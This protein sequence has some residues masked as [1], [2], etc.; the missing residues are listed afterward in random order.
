MTF[1][2]PLS[3]CLSVFLSVFLYLFLSLSLSLSRSVLFRVA[4]AL[5]KLAEPAILAAEDAGELFR[6]LRELGHDIVDPAVLIAAAY[7]VCTA[8]HELDVRAARGTGPL[9]R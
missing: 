4:M 7:K 6:V 3:V 5:L 9:G 1:P 8:V 2:L